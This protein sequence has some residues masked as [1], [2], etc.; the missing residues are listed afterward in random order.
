MSNAKKKTKS[1]KTVAR[2]SSQKAQRRASLASIRSPNVDSYEHERVLTG[3]TDPFSSEAIT[4][5]YPDQGSGRTL[6]FQRRWQFT[7]TANAAGDIVFSINTKPNFPRLDGTF[8]AN[9]ATWPATYT[10]DFTSDIM[11]VN[12]RTYRPITCGLRVVNTLSA[13]NSQGS[14]VIAKGGP[15]VLSSNTS[16]L[17]SLFTSWDL[18]SNVHGGEWHTTSHPLTATAYALSEISGYN[19]NT[20]Q[21]N[22]WENIYFYASGLPASSSPFVFELI[23]NYEYTPRE[24]TALAQ[25]AQRQ[26]VMNVSMQTAVNQVQNSVPNSHAANRSSTS[27]VIKREAKKALLKHVLPFAVRKA[28]QFLA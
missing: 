20:A 3:L 4:A 10:G 6:T 19:T 1:K 7:L 26:P 13:T 11:N 18:H 8:A 16:F 17:P 5:R 22:S 14:I 23:T 27:A 15:P 9:V 2:G 12:A 25:L 21:D 24:D 28:E